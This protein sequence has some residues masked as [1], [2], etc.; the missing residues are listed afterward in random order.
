M[1]FLFVI[2]PIKNINPLKDSSAA[3][4]QASSKKSIEIWSCTPQDLEARGDEVWASSVKV[5][6]NPWISFKENDCI[7][8]AEF[9]CIW[10]RKDPPVNEAY[11]YATHLLEVAE[12]KGVKVVNKPSSLRAWNEKLGALRYSHLMAPTIV[13]SKVKDLINFA[14]I[15]NEV[16]IKPLG[17]KGGQGVIRINKN[18]PGIKSIIELITSQEELPVMMQKFIP[19]VIEGDKRIIIVNGEAIGSINRIPQGG[20]FRS[21]LA[22][23]GKAEP[24]LLTEKEKSIC[25]ELSQHFKDEGLF[26]VGIDVIN[27]MLS[28]INVTSPTG[29]RE[30]ENLSNKNV[31]A[32][33]IEKLLEI[34]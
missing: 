30:I 13:A 22:M 32:E 18:S 14:N 16:V 10:M 3:L 5:E 29:L 6:V 4:M 15:N 20:D 27:G 33:V 12:R 8:L 11:L 25:S 17:G 23:G 9:N 26:F 28:E 19:E 2:D 7:P 24:T 31:S 21:N 1:K 34:I